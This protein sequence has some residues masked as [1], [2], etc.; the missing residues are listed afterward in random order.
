MAGIYIHLPFCKRKCGYCDFYSVGADSKTIENYVR[1]L[2]E[3]IRLR[4]AAFPYSVETIYLG[5]GT[6][7]LVPSTLIERLIDR[8]RNTFQCQANMEISMEVNPGTVEKASWCAYQ[9]AGINR[10]SL[11]VQ[12]FLDH[13]LACLGRIHQAATAI[14]A[15][16]DAR[17]CGF[18]NIGIDLIYGLPGQTESEW[19]KNLQQ[20]IELAPDHISTYCLSLSDTVPMAKKIHNGALPPLD[21]DL[22]AAF[23][24]LAHEFLT[25]AGYRHYEISNYAKPGFECQHNQIYWDGGPYLGLGASAHSFNEKRRFWNV[26]NIMQYE[27]LLEQEQLP[28]ETEEA[29]S[30]SQL[31][32][33]QLA[34]GLRTDTGVPLSFIGRENMARILVEENKAIIKKDRFILTLNGF[35][36][37]DEIAV[38]LME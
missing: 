30:P 19:K 26:A 4:K 17:D 25:K 16:Q 35:M 14:Q 34:L 20:A 8:V 11:G 29:L 9:N 38:Q 12:S 15:Y 7:S 10:I 18:D 24:E 37:A 1:L 27:S 33:E 21:E 23:M 5:G 31:R 28:V 2:H 22:G 32:M 6:P 13:E 3:E 36:L